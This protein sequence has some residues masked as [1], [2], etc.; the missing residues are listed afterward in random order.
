MAKRHITALLFGVATIIGASS[1]SFDGDNATT[2]TAQ[3]EPK[4]KKSRSLSRCV[5]YGQHLGEDKQSVDISL[6]NRCRMP[7]SCSVEWKITCDGEDGA[8]H[9]SADVLRLVKGAR[10][11]LNASAAACG[12]EGWAVDDIKWEC[13]PL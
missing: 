10:E 8:G 6:R 3:A 12:D 7:V 4:A 13:E 2:N 1:V 5:K 9:E 11:T